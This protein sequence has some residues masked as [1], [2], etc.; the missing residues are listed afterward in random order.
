MAR[1]SPRTW[2]ALSRSGGGLLGLVVG[3]RGNGGLRGSR[4]VV[5]P[6]W[7]IFVISHINKIES[8]KRRGCWRHKL[9]RVHTLSTGFACVI[10][11]AC[12]SSSSSPATG[13]SE[14][15]D[16]GT[17][18]HS[19][20]GGRIWAHGGLGQV[21]VMLFAVIPDLRQLIWC[22]T[23]GRLIVPFSSCS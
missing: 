14:R 8:R 12:R 7:P 18:S 23:Y 15:S 11:C 1:A 17:T 9:S 16:P 13:A 4:S 22:I 6:S 5:G 10:C 21:C 2:R 20:D 19:L 3:W